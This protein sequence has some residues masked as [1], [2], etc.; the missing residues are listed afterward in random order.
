MDIV[1]H[2]FD[3]YAGDAIYSH[4][5]NPFAKP[6][7]LLFASIASNVTTSPPPPVVSRVTSLLASLP[8]LSSLPR[9][10]IIR[11]CLSLYVL[12]YIGIVLLYFSIA[13]F[14]YYFIFDHRMEQHPRFLQN[15][16]KKEIMFSLEAFPMLD[17]LTLPWF[18]GDVRGHS[19]LYD[20]IAEGP[21]GA[22]GGWLPY[23]YLAV[24]ALAFLIFT[25]YAIYWIHRWLHIPFFYKRLHK[26]HHKWI[27]PTPFASHAFHPVDGYLQSVPYHMCCYMF[28]IHKYMF[29]GLFTFVN[30]WSIFIH[31]SDMLSDSPLIHYI[32]GPAHHTLHHIYFNCNYGQYFTWGDKL[33]G[34]FR[35]PAVEDD[36]LIAVL[37]VIAKKKAAAAEG[38]EK[39]IDYRNGEKEEDIVTLETKKKQ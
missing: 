14:S 10:S 4:L 22:K 35:A 15:Q 13:T 16:V 12:V 23:A 32:N 31:D 6:S 18:L 33:G 25:D 24:S 29:V 30:I 3:E 5:D 21:F 39:G 11:Q 28:P 38:S 9:D 20:S 2:Y 36:P 19:M 37:E 34:S 26:P 27:V 1:L 7:N 8:S 17:L